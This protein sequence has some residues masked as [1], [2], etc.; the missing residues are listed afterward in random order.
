M[1]TSTSRALV[2]V[3]LVLLI[4]FMITAPMMQGG[5]DVELPRAEARPLSPKEGMVVTV[6][7]DGR[8]FVDQTPV[9][10][11]D[12]RVTFRS[13]VAHAEAA[14]GV[15]PGGRR[16]A[17]R[18]GRAGPGGD[19]DG[20]G[21]RTWDSWPRRKNRREVPERRPGA[22]RPGGRAWPGRSWCTRPRPLPGAPAAAL[23][24]SPRS[25]PWT[26]SPP[27]ALRRSELAAAPRRRPTPP[28]RREAAAPGES[29]RRRQPKPPKAR[30][31][32]PAP[33]PPPPPPSRK[34]RSRRPRPRRRSRRLPGE[35]PSTGTD[36]ATI[37]TPGPRVSLSRVSAEHRDPDLSALGPELGQQSSFAEFSFLILRDGSVRDIRFV[38]RSG[39]FAFDLDAQGAIEA[40]GNAKAFG[41]LPDG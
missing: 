38:T 4:I 20:R 29:R 19:P 34:E 12:F 30:P 2:D 22:A 17:L 21:R 27:P 10:Y 35:T 14:G 31:A 6:N 41:P 24:G 23:Q 33:K 16:C 26:W 32:A 36:V 37:K 8:I 5:V 1:P 7:R 3:M 39:N 28:P 9:T 15:P 25:T 18:R 13:L 40:A 11:N